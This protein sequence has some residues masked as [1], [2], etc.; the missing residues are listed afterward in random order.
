VG[1]KKWEEIN[2]LA[3]DA[4]AGTNFG[5]D[6]FE[7]SHPYEGSSPVDLEL[8][9]PIWEY[10]HSLGCSVSGGAV[11]RGSLLEWQGI[12]LYSDFCSGLVWGLLKTPV[13]DWQNK[14]LFQAG[15][16][17]AAI[18]QDESGEVYLVDYEGMILKLAPQ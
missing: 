17:I 16:R 2:Y 9:D 10:D 14:Q 5:W 18:D 4:P 6:Y 11:Y 1:Q 8:I 7:G 15:G 12:Y 13:G 3:A